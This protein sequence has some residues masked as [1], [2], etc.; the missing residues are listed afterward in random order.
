MKMK[1][2]TAAGLAAIAAA[3]SFSGFALAA[4]PSDSAG[5]GAEAPG[6]IVGSAEG[7]VAVFPPDGGDPVKMTDIELKTLPGADRNALEDGIFV[8]NDEE[9]ARILED[10]GS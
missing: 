9:L 3:V 10:L 4:A 6:Y 2:K 7:K 5:S 8:E 1:F